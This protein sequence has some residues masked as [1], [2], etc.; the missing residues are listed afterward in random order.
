MGVWLC[1][2]GDRSSFEGEVQTMD[3]DAQALNSAQFHDAYIRAIC[4]QEF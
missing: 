2:P 1:G 4:Q 3:Y